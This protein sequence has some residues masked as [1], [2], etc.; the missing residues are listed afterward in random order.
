MFPDIN[1]RECWKNGILQLIEILE[2]TTFEYLLAFSLARFGRFIWRTPRKGTQPDWRIF[3][4]F[5][6][7]VYREIR[8]IVLHI[9]NL[10]PNF[11]RRT[12]SNRIAVS[13]L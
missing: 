2:R 5:L 10:L 4:E 13:L 6:N 11:V 3:N 7:L 8:P 1:P 9:T 12:S